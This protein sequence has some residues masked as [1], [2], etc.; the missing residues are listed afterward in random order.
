MTFSSRRK[1]PDNEHPAYKTLRLT[2]EKPIILED[3]QKKHPVYGPYQGQV[4]LQVAHPLSREV[5]GRPQW[6]RLN[7]YRKDVPVKLEWLPK[8]GPALLQAYKEGE[9][10][11]PIS[12]DR[13][14]VQADKPPAVLLLPSGRYRLTRQ[15]AEGR[16]EPL[17][18][19]EVP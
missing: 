17:E 1:D 5:K 11:S 12:V 2:L 19:L 8:E 13:L 9:T 16:E 7:G 3:D 10:I 14:L 4:D 18:T 15:D 6:M